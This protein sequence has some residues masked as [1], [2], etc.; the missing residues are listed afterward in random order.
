[1]KIQLNLNIHNIPQH[2]IHNQDLDLIIL[3]HNIH[4]IK[5]LITE[6]NK[7]T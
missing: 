1:M 6:I 4:T 3:I 5:K 2:I 7:I